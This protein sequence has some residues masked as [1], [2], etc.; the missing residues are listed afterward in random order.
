MPWVLSNC[1]S[2]A[3][4]YL[5]FSFK[6]PLEKDFEDFFLD[7]R[8]PY[9]VAFTNWHVNYQNTEFGVSFCLIKGRNNCRQ[10][11]VCYCIIWLEK[12]LNLKRMQKKLTALGSSFNLSSPRNLFLLTVSL[13]EIL[14]SGKNVFFVTDYI[15]HCEK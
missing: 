15:S 5:Y 12:G 7:R 11:W 6:T 9:L 14:M 2:S 1:N 10:G 3:G 8:R 13:F 4:N